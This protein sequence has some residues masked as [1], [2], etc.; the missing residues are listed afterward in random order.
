MITKTCA[1]NQFGASTRTGN[2]IWSLWWMWWVSRK[3]S[4]WRLL[5]IS[6]T[7]R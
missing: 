6:F 5:S 7:N 4:P 3:T 1:Q 2:R